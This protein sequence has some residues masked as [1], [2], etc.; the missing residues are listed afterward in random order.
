VVVGVARRLQLESLFRQKCERR[1]H[2]T[3]PGGA[4]DSPSG[5]R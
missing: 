2:A 5:V 3:A 4:G 1:R